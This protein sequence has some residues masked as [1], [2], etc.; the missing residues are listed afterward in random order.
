MPAAL[1]TGA[2]VRIGRALALTLA[3]QGFDVGVHYNSSTKDAEA[4]ASEVIAKGKTAATLKAD[5]SNETEVSTLI[6]RACESL[7]PLSLL[8]NNA[9]V[10]EFDDIETMTRAS[11]DKHIETNLRAPLKLAQDFAAQ[12][13]EGAQIINVIDQRVLKLT[14]QFLS[15]TVSKAALHT[16]TVTLAQALG[17]KGIRVNAIGPGPTLKN[18][19]QSDQDWEQ[20]T[21]STILGKGATPGDICDA[22]VYLISAASV[23]GQMI[24]VDGGQHLGWRTPDV[25]VKE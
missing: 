4:V 11:W 7:G 8:V 24:A 17:P 5:L 6:N 3:D 16:L 20:Q 10:F 12:A 19:R 1:V 9:S 2:G 25:L 13:S 14:P 21:G 18:A 15:Y 23:T 22:L